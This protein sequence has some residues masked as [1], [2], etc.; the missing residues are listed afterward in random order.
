[1]CKGLVT[2]SE[3]SHSDTYLLEYF[4]DNSW[5]PNNIEVEEAT[6]NFCNLRY[7]QELS[8][9]MNQIWTAFL[10]VSQTFHWGFDDIL[11]EEPQYRVLTSKQLIDFSEENI[12]KLKKEVGKVSNGLTNAPDVLAKL[13]NLTISNYDNPAWKRDAIDMART[14]ANR[15]L[16]ASLGQ[17]TIDIDT[18]NKDKI[19]AKDIRQLV[20]LS[21]KILASLSEVLAMSDDFSMHHSLLKLYDAEQINGVPPL[22][23]PHTELTLKGNAEVDY[24]RSHH[25]ELVEHVFQPELKVYGDW[26]L[27]QIKSGNRAEWKRPEIFTEQGAIIKDRFYDT[28]LA[29]MAP[30][31]ERNAHRLIDA[32]SRLQNNVSELLPMCD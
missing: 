5:Q 23:N 17:T 6:D 32:F 12:L 14:I 1:M 10:P 22:I 3:L 29:E 2:W 18:W 30:K 8:T 15:A 16:F 11:Y 20:K 4:A 26:I 7:P 31:K 19:G 24:C 28:P 9:E 27:K 13:A 21:Q 25:Y